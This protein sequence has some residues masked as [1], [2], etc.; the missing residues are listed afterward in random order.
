VLIRNEEG[1]RWLPLGVAAA[2]VAVVGFLAYQRWWPH[3]ST[4]QVSVDQ[5]LDR[6]RDGMGTAPAA[7]VPPV[8]EPVV[9]TEPATVVE[10]VE[11]T[12]PAPAPV[13]EPAATTEP[14]APLTLPS[15]GVYLYA[16]EGREHVTAL[17]GTEHIYPAETTITVTPNGCGVHLRWD[18][19]AERY[20]EW[21]LCVDDG[22]IT[23]QPTG[24]QFH[25][26]FGQ[27]QTDVSECR[28]TVPL[29]PPPAEGTAIGRN[30]RLASER[31]NPV[32]TAGPAGTATVGGV[33]VTTTT[34]DV[35]ITL[36]GDYPEHSTQHWELGPDGLPVAIT[37][38][39]ESANPSP[40]GSVTYTETITAT[41]TSLDPLS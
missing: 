28:A 8:V 17:G 30:C 27:S 31:W 34:F 32:W 29:N 9:T 14:P 23:L 22:A 24:V 35:A 4:T 21:N 41:L 25:Q 36:D 6:Y 16:T 10:P 40:V 39:M 3:D 13:T 7:P 18:L 20:E 38:N 33:E 15:A 1:V 11:T 2:A 26:F 12:S 5:V 19:L 37:W